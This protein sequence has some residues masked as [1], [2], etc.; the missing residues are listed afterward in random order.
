MGLFSAILGGTTSRLSSSIYKVNKRA[1]SF[2]DRKTYTPY[3]GY[4][5]SDRTVYPR[6]TQ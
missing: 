5:S 3:K 2:F 4:K 1:G 6:R